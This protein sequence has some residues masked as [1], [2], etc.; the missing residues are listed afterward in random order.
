MT[1]KLKNKAVCHGEIIFQE[2]LHRQ[3]KIKIK[4]NETEYDTVV[5]KNTKNW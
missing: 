3:K 2:L 1:F 5:T 4:N